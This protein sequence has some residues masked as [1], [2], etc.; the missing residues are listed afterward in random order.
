[1][2]NWDDCRVMWTSEVQGNLADTATYNMKCSTLNLAFYP[3]YLLRDK[4]C[5][6]LERKTLTARPNLIP[7][8]CCEEISL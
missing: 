5:G 4:N 7:Y 8:P 6:T 1:M 2:S 3:I